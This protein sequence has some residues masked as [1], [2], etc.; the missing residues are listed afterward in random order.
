MDNSLPND[1]P[2]QNNNPTPASPTGGPP[3]FGSNFNPHTNPPNPPPTPQP[4][5]NPLHPSIH[6]EIAQ[7]RPRDAHGHF[8]PYKHPT[9]QI[10]PNTQ[11][12]LPPVINITENTK[13]S[14][15]KDPPL[16]N[17]NISVTNPVTY[18]KKWVASFLKNQDIDLRLRIK[19]FAT[20]G[21]VLGF[22][23]V[24]GTAFSI[25][26]YFFPHSSPIFHRQ[27]VYPGVVQKG[28]MGQYFLM[29][30]DS[31]LWK[32]KP[33]HNN[34]NLSSLVNK[35]VVITGNLTAEKYLIEVAE[36]IVVDT[37]TQASVTQTPPTSLT[38][39]NSPNILT[40]PNQD[41][42]PKL[43]SDITWE[44]NQKKIL[45]FTSGKR[46]IELEGV[47]LES[48]QVTDF[49]Q[50]FLNY[51]TSQLTQLNFKQT[52][53]SKTPDS[54]TQSYEK[55]GLYLTFGVENVYTGSRKSKKISGYKAYIEHN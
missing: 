14:E 5:P 26:R 11:T 6:S 32:V 20:I 24:G 7:H 25:G 17:A 28:N 46:R 1:P 18:F 9:P 30:S 15:G 42:L 55:D 50:A 37:L 21:L 38:S 3:P 49:P 10:S 4:D 53:N 12:S 2:D 39:P 13:Y 40:I 44:T 8:L 35:Q 54:I 16:V 48:A 51:Y 43:Y 36:V 19:P 34:I 41:L 33:K 52:L 27:V 45:T 23:L 22:G 29:S 31:T 47:Y